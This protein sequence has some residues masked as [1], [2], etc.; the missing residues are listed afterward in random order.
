MPAEKH[1]VPEEFPACVSIFTVRLR[2]VGCPEIRARKIKGK[3][4]ASMET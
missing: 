3:T 4:N 2:L 1:K